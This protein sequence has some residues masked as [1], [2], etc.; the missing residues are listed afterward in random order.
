MRSWWPKESLSPVCCSAKAMYQRCI[1]LRSC[2]LS[3][4]PAPELKPDSK[5]VQ[6]GRVRPIPQCLRIPAQNNCVCNTAVLKHW[7]LSGSRRPARS[8][9]CQTRAWPRV[10]RTL[11]NPR[12]RPSGTCRGRQGIAQCLLVLDW[13]NASSFLFSVPPFGAAIVVAYSAGFHFRS[14][15]SGCGERSRRPCWE[16]KE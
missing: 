1:C 3:S 2:R 12:D 13:F 5:T 11:Q 15:T 6:Q 10:E 16:T 8:R 4:G 14:R 7:E 9:T